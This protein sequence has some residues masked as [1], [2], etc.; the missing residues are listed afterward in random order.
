MALF[1]VLRLLL[2]IPINKPA[3]SN[4]VSI[5]ISNMIVVSPLILLPH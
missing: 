1:L 5:V 3:P 2:T 4:V